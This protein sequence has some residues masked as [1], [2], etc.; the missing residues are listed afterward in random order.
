[1]TKLEK[2]NG[3][4][5]EK[6]NSVKDVFKKSFEEDLEVGASFAVT[7]NGNYVVDIWGGYAD[8]AK[9]QPWERDTIVNVYSTTKFMAAVCVHMLVDRGL[10][11]YDDP[12]AKYWPEFAQGGK[13]NLPV[14][15][16]LSHTAGLAGFDK[17]IRAKTLFDWDQIVNLLS[18]QKPWW[19]PGTKSGYHILSFGY[20]LGELVRHI[21][22]KS[23]GTFFKEEVALP[24]NADFYIGL[25][26]QLDPRVAELIPPQLNLAELATME[27]GSIS[28]RAIGNPILSIPLTKT[29]EWRAAEIPSANGHGNARSVAKVAA[30][31]ACGGELNNIHLVSPNIISQSIE[32]QSYNKDLVINIPVRFGLGWGINSKEMPISP[33]KN[34]FFWAGYG[35]SIVIVDLDAKMSISYVMNKMVAT[36]SGDPRSERLINAVYNSL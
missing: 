19:E 9:S 29:R 10:L 33:N 13:E 26:E 5:D 27:P 16:L 6:F 35:G 24:L 34:A 22:G 17:K 18:A 8:A 14:R 11:N 15:Y 1:M 32:E 3:F 25:P 12:V 7:I 31:L 36:L 23:I 2:I 30:A 21:T 20:L 28:M 4:C